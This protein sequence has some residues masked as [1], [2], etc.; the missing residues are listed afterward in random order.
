MRRYIRSRLV[1][2][3]GQERWASCF[4]VHKKTIM[5]RISELEQ[6]TPSI[7]AMIEFAKN[8]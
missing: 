7:V 2:P 4:N 3:Q 8:F 6:E 5:R 1:I